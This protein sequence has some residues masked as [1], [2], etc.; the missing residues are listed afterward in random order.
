[1][2]AHDPKAFACP[3]VVRAAED[4][5]SR[6]GLRLQETVELRRPIEPE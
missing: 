2:D 6:Y 4:M 1:M 3:E 5:V